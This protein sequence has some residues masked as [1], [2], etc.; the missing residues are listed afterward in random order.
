MITWFL[1]FLSFMFPN[2]DPDERIAASLLSSGAEGQSLSFVIILKDQADLQGVRSIH[3]K[4]AKAQKVFSLL[5]EKAQATQGPVIRFLEQEGAMAQSFYLVN[6]IR[7]YGDL[8]LMRRLASL[9]QVAYLAADSPVQVSEV[10]EDNGPVLR[11]FQSVTWGIARIQADSVWAMGYTGQGVVIGG[12]DTGYEWDNPYLIHTYRGWQNGAAD[13]NYNWHD[14]IHELNPQNGDTTSNP[15]NNPCGLDVDAPCDDHNHGTHTMG[16]MAGIDSSNQI[17]VAPG[18]TWIGC[19]NM[20]RGWGTP[21]TYIECFEWFLAP[22]DLDGLN[23][24]PAMAPHVIN[25]SWSCPEVEGCD[26]SNFALMEMAVNNLRAAGTVV[27]V[28]AGNSGSGCGSVSTPSAIFESSFTVGA[29]N[30]VDTIAGFSS[31]GPVTVDGSL[32]MKPNVVAP[33]VG[34][35]SCI[36]GGGFASWAGTSMAGPHVAGS[37]ALILSARPDL[38]GEVDAIEDLLE[39]TA[40]VLLSPDTCSGFP[41]TMVPNQAYGWGRINVFEAVKKALENSSVDEPDG[42]GKPQIWPNPFQNDLHIRWADQEG[43]AN[44]ILYDAIGQPVWRQEVWS[45]PQSQITLSPTH[46]PSGFY[47]LVIRVGDRSYPCTVLHSA[48]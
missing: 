9:P 7:S 4:E 19:R 27:V 26:P 43:P 23:P 42:L 17:G 45:V 16:T 21:S 15:L 41:G 39:S 12:Q 31:R 48:H 22:T 29:S 40:R 8:D 37:V 2:H 35:R 18:A 25:N 10:V 3:G 32:R 1:L 24:D 36:R 6:A 20:E 11:E 30:Q 44:L 46:L 28:S 13:H 14:A 33:G 5:Q 47:T 38:A 34:V